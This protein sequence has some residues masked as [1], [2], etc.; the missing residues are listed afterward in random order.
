MWVRSTSYCSHFCMSVKACGTHR[1]AIFPIHWDSFRMW[2]IVVCDNPVS[3][4]NS[5]IVWRRYVSSNVEKLMHLFFTDNEDEQA[6][7]YLSHFVVPR[8]RLLFIVSLFC[9]AVQIPR[10]PLEDLYDTVV[11]YCLWRIQSLSNSAVPTSKTSW[12]HYTRPPA[13]TRL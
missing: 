4:A 3:K 8:W 12:Q 7:A 11:P 13:N 9:R 6:E 1:D 2:N 10:K 5:Q